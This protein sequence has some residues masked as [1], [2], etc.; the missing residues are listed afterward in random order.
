VTASIYLSLTVIDSG[1]WNVNIEPPTRKCIEIFSPLRSKLS[2]GKENNPKLRA[3][4]PISNMRHCKF[5]GVI[6]VRFRLLFQFFFSNKDNSKNDDAT[7][8]VLP[9]LEDDEVGE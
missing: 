4:I 6:Y 3:N 5:L 8:C 9:E 2:S 1:N 7:S